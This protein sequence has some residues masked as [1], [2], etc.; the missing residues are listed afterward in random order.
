MNSKNPVIKNRIRPFA[1]R[2]CID[3]LL[4]LLIIVFSIAIRLPS[5]HIEAVP[6]ASDRLNFMTAEGLPYLSEMDSYHYAKIA[7]SISEEMPADLTSYPGLPLLGYVIWKVVSLFCTVSLYSILVYISPFIASLAA[8]PAYVFVRRRTGRLG[9][10]TA[11]MM[12]ALTASFLIKTGFAFFD[13][14]ALLCLLPLAMICCFIESVENSSL[15]RSCAWGLLSAFSFTYLTV[16]WTGFKI[17]FYL[18]IG[19]WIILLFLRLFSKSDKT[20]RTF[21]T[22]T[23]LIAVFVLITYS[24]HGLRSL[25][26]S[27]YL[28]KY[29]T[30]DVVDLSTGFPASNIFIEELSDMPLI[31]KGIFD[32][33]QYGIINRLGGIIIVSVSFISIIVM[34]CKAVKILIS[35][36]GRSQNS[37]ADSTVAEKDSYDENINII[38]TTAAFALW[39]VGGA[40]MPAFGAR[41][42]ELTAI[43]FSIIVGLGIGYFGVA[44]KRIGLGFSSW[45]LV[46]AIL[47]PPCVGAYHLASSQLSPIDDTL[48]EACEYID[49]HSAKDSVVASW[50]DFGYYY[51]YETRRIA[52]AN[53]GTFDG[54]TYYWLAKALT[55][56]DEGLSAGIFRMMAS[57]GMHASQSADVIAGDSKEGS[58]L[59]ERLLKM[60]PDEGRQYLM[61]T[62][63]DADIGKLNE[64]A[65]M[66]YPDYVPEIAV[67]ITQDMFKKIGAISYY[68]LWDFSGN[69][70]STSR[71]SENMMMYRLYADNKGM[72]CFRYGKAFE[73]PADICSCNVWFIPEMILE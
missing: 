17:Y 24:I 25:D 43:P 64:L 34:I 70:L 37:D 1:G 32:V 69:D 9:A 19:I 30:D 72:E 58:I 52:L 67:I 14:D 33:T 16:T 45:V 71:A 66:M 20:K 3:V 41:F 27:G 47:I 18:A 61:D 50:W 73:D 36:P 49:E 60:K 10:F 7:R 38:I 22:G 26:I 15:I 42:I 46:L 65:D 54:R 62:Y 4:V 44:F 53:G 56:D 13:T 28:H 29:A 68:G 6:D 21:L 35:L 48:Q 57:C 8:I 11:G 5:L 2:A 31:A 23:V 59:I 55:T 63:A 51:E 39:A 12:A 40:V